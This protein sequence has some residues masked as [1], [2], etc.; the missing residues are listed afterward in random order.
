MAA[1]PAFR[2]TSDQRRA[3]ASLRRTPVRVEEPEGEVPVVGGVGQEDMELSRRPRLHLRTSSPGRVGGAGLV[4]DDQLPA[5][6]RAA[7]GGGWRE[8]GGRSTD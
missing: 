7:P 1:V 8:S 2:S 4:P 3:S 5:R 6:R